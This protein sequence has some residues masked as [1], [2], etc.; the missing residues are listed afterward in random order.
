MGALTRT[1]T[2]ANEPR[3]ADGT[4]FVIRLPSIAL[5]LLAGLAL[6][7]LVAYVLAPGEGLGSDLRL[8][9]H[10]AQVLADQGPGGF[11]GNAGFADYPPG[12][13]YVLWVLGVA[14][15]AIAGLLGL[16]PAEVIAALIKLP[17]NT[18]LVQSEPKLFE[19]DISE[20]RA[21]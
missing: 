15:D 1:D 10:W 13:L 12:Y 18:T 2:P 8:F 4:H 17:L 16:A 7:L 20:G 21:G 5:V 11:Y 3:S 19:V 9:G 14:G 6:R